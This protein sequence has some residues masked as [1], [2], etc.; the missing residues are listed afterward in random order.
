MNC[1]HSCKTEYKFKPHEKVCQNKDFW[2]IVMPSE[3]NKMVEFNIWSHGI[4][5]WKIDGCADNPENS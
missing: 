4:F 3:K 5:N 2:G 1:L